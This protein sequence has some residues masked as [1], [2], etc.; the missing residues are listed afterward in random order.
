MRRLHT[1][2]VAL[3]V[4]AGARAAQEPK[5]GNTWYEDKV[6][7]GFKLKAPK[8]WEFVP[9]SPLEANLIG[10]DADPGEG[11]YVPLGKDAEIIAEIL[12]VKFDRREKKGAKETRQIGN[13]T[14]EIDMKGFTDVGLWM[15]RA[16]DEGDGWHRVEGPTPLKGTNLNATLS[17]YEGMSSRRSASNAVPQP[18]SAYVASYSLGPE[19]DVAFIGLGPAGKKWRTFE[20]SYAALAKTLQPLAL[21][22]SVAGPIDGSDPRAKKRA[23]LQA[24]MAKTPGWSLYETPN[25]FIVSCY[26]DKQFI[27]EL[28]V[29]LE[30]IRQVYEKDYPPSLARMIKPH[31]APET[32]GGGES[33]PAREPQDPQRTVSQPAPVDALELGRNSVVRLCKDRGQYLQYGGPATS[34]GYFNSMEEELVIYDAKQDEGRDKTW[35][36]MNH[37]GFHQYIHAFFGNLAPHSWYNEGTGDYYSGFDFNLKTK[38]FTPKPEVGRQDNLLL[39]REDYVPLQ[40]FVRWTKAQYYAMPPSPG[41]SG[42]PLQGW[43]CYAQGWSLIW[44]LRTGEGKAKGWQ[45]PWGTILDKYLQTLLETGDIGKAVDAAFQ[46]VDWD[47]FEAC[48][49]G[50]MI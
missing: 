48:W 5:P 12:L 4:L 28:K 16:L 39:I 49:K 34:S 1:L 18:V 44:F 24:D 8:D 10:K 30:G 9:G 46:G 25:Y 15:E 27:E 32:E 42:K 29:R 14:V 6:D 26:D 37:E 38:K 20:S 47:A 35:G 2:G 13:E 19:L 22:N 50:Y 40:E 23:K 31:A 43:A 33:E 45:K 36:V 21:T 7:L 41:R 11:K 3:V 17:I